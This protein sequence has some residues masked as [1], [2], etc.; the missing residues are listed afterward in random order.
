MWL[1]T[2]CLY[3]IFFVSA[4]N[5]AANIVNNANENNNNNNNND[6]QDNTNNNNQVIFS[7]DTRVQYLSLIDTRSSAAQQR[8]TDVSLNKNKS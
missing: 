4:V 3:F 2:L 5:V 6:N 1:W 8:G 7:I